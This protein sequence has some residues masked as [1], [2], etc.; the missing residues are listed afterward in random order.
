[1]S[2]QT[3]H[4][5]PSLDRDA[6]IIN[7][8]LAEVNLHPIDFKEEN[9]IIFK[10]LKSKHIAGIV[11][12]EIYHDI[13]LLRSLAVRPVYRGQKIGKS[14]ID[15]LTHHA[16]RGGLK[17]IWLLTETAEDYFAKQGFK[18]VDR[19]LVSPLIKTCRQYRVLC[20]DSAIVMLKNLIDHED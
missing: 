13:G 9:V 6:P 8:I 2:L 19:T 15:H 14:L 5:D 3:I 18:T 11:G 1:M 4:I 7:Q 20:P 17:E 10:A 12:L 16:I